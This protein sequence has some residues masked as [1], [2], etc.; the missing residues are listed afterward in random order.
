MKK[1]TFRF[2]QIAIV[3]LALSPS[4]NSLAQT[5]SYQDL[6]ALAGLPTEQYFPQLTNYL[7]THTNH[8]NVSDAA[9]SGWQAGIMALIINAHLDLPGITS[10]VAVDTLPNRSGNSSYGFWSTTNGPDPGSVFEGLWKGARLSDYDRERWNLT[11]EYGPIPP[12]GRYNFFNDRLNWKI[13]M[14]TNVPDS[15]LFDLVQSD[16]PSQ[17]RAVAAY[18][19]PQRDNETVRGFLFQQLTNTG[20]D[21]N[22]RQEIISGLGNSNPSYLWPLLRDVYGILGLTDSNISGVGVLKGAP[23][24]EAKAFLL[25]ALANTNL[26]EGVRLGA[27][28]AID[29]ANPN[30][31]GVLSNLVANTNTPRE[32]M[33]YAAGSLE[34]YPVSQVTNFLQSINLNNYEEAVQVLL[35]TAPANRRDRTL[36]DIR[37]VLSFT[38]R[39]DLSTEVKSTVARETLFMARISHITIS[40]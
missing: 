35:I 36:D 19:L 27:L 4:P 6:V 15:L 31:F 16:A 33:R 21:A 28:H 12:A 38:N 22:V 8:I 7:A 18:C 24:P 14:P 39:A 37:Y 10:L 30:A 25:S 23:Q 9:Q 29:P 32:L 11:N 26:Q 1:L 20:G 3:F 13:Q 2:V 17:M 5:N 34:N 40:P